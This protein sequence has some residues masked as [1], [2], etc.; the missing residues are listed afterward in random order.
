MDEIIVSGEPDFSKKG[1]ASVHALQEVQF[2]K[3]ILISVSAFIVFYFFNVYIK[4]TGLPS[5]GNIFA[6]PL[7]L[8]LGLINLLIAPV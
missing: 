1:H 4:I 6:L 7:N 2:S 8:E 5:D 3:K